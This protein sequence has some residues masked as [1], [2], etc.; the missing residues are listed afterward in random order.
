MIRRSIVFACGVL[1]MSGCARDK[2]QPTASAA[3]PK[4][5][6]KA[7][8]K[9]PG[10]S[11]TPPKQVERREMPKPTP[12]FW[13]HGQKESSQLVLSTHRTVFHVVDKATQ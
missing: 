9:A 11:R 10:A 1:V 7:P 8:V 12:W 2:T 3:S 6:T 4:G 5:V 13:R